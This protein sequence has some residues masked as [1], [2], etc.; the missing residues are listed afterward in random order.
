MKYGRELALI[1]VLFLVSGCGSLSS[2]WRGSAGAYPGVRFD[3]EQVTHYTTEGEWIALF[4][5]PL[6]ALVDTLC[7]PYDLTNDQETAPAV[8]SDSYSR[9]VRVGYK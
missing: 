5:I 1:V 9:T 8:P 7:L 4:D 3:S 2:R 6:S